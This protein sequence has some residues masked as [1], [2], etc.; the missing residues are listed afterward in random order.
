MIFHYTRAHETQIWPISWFVLQLFFKKKLLFHSFF[1][2]LPPR[3]LPGALGPFSKERS[4]NSASD[5]TPKTS[6]RW[7]LT[8][9]RTVQSSKFHFFALQTEYDEGITTGNSGRLILL[10]FYHMIDPSRISGGDAFI[11]SAGQKDKRLAAILR[12]SFLECLVPHFRCSGGLLGALGAR[13]SLDRGPH[14]PS[15][16]R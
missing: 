5:G 1:N 11:T 6:V 13:L 9:F 12:I 15:K 10:G 3:R 2:F 8:R 4:R 7:N 16:N 14:L